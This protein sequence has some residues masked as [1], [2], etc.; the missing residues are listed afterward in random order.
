MLP[1]VRLKSRTPPLAKGG[2]GGYLREGYSPPAHP[3]DF[4][5]KVDERQMELDMHAVH[6]AGIRLADARKQQAH[7]RA[8]ARCLLRDDVVKAELRSD[9]SVLCTDFNG[10]ETLRMAGWRGR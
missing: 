3:R 1:Y 8:L 4:I 6:E 10:R 7:E 9:G 2:W 5:M